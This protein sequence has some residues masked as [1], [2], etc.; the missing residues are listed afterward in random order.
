MNPDQG[1][2][3]RTDLEALIIA[4]SRTLSAE[5]DEIGRLFAG[6][7]QVH[8]S[9]F[10]ALLHV[11][12]AEAAGTPLSAG[13]LRHK[14]GVSGAAVTYLVERMVESGHLRRES[15]PSDRRKVILRYA[16][17]GRDVAAAFF[18]PL[19]TY[20]HEALAD[21][22][23][24][25]LAAAHRVFTALVEAMRRFRAELGA[26]GADTAPRDTPGDTITTTGKR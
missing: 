12:V 15:D 18:A 3:E 21:L 26:A 1:S 11:L 16:D 14:M 5:S 13:E 8:L 6:L 4:D 19:G 20:T 25:D 10:R 17:H 22:P 9:D 23:D 7:H 2:V 24:S